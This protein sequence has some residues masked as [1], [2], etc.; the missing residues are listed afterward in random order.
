MNRFPSIFQQSSSIFI[1]FSWSF[2]GFL[3]DLGRLLVVFKAFQGFERPGETA[4]VFV[5][6]K[7]TCDALEKELTWDPM[8]AS[9][10]LCAWCRALHGDKEWESL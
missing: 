9:A 6:R 3:M 8:R 1:H 4:M 5:G 7:K 10:P 2:H